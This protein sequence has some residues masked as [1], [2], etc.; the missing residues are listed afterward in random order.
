MSKG[1]LLFVSSVYALIIIATLVM[2]QYAK[3]AEVKEDDTGAI[4]CD[5]E[6]C[7][8]KILIQIA[9][10]PQDHLVNDSLLIFPKP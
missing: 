4:S 1:D 5:D 6:I 10:E 2:L 3:A 7:K 8:H 9:N